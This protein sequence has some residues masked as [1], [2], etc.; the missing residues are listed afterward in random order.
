MKRLSKRR[1]RLSPEEILR[2]FPPL[3]SAI[4]YAN[5]EGM[6]HRDIKPSNI[7][8][9]RKGDPVLTD[10]GIARIAGAT[11]YTMPGTVVGSAQYMSPEQAQ[12]QLADNR[13]DI[14][15]LGICLFEALTGRVPFD[16]ETTATILAQHLTAPVPVARLLNP[17]LP[18]E[19]EAVLHRVLSKDPALRYQQAAD[20]AADL[21]TALRP[22]LAP[23]GATVVETVLVPPAGATRVEEQVPVP[24]P[25]PAPESPPTP[26]PAPAPTPYVAPPITPP[27]GYPVQ[28]GYQAPAGY[29]APGTYPPAG[30]APWVAP[31]AAAPWT[32]AAAPPAYGPGIYPQAAAP[33]PG[34]PLMPA[35][36]PAPRRRRRWPLILIIVLLLAAAGAVAFVLLRPKD[37][38]TTSTTVAGSGTTGGGSSTS[39]SGTTATTGAA[40]AAAL[41]EADSLMS[42][43]KIQEAVTKYQ[44]IL[45]TNPE[46]DVV[47]T[48]LGIAYALIK[49]QGAGRGTTHRGDGGQPFQR[50]GLDLPR[51]RPL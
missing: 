28:G 48:Q 19:V 17:D 2:I 12:G 15:S 6:V 49:Q 29:P 41:A 30:Q 10:Y 24:P 22:L 25:T 50:Q 44:A 46:N 47:L 45:Q 33:G 43:G 39:G 1:Q 3:C 38:S 13:S 42:E 32:P 36:A 31:P 26:A 27:G 37:G 14:Y 23:A 40:D 35:A 16:G 5:R 20:L 9:T 21:D 8:L 7:I 18:P 51:P 34:V 4:D 11:S